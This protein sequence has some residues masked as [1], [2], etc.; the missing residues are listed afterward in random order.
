[1]KNLIVTLT[2]I[3]LTLTACQADEPTC[4]DYLDEQIESMLLICEENPQLTAACGCWE[5]G[6]DLN[7]ETCGCMPEGKLEEFSLRRCEPADEGWLLEAA[8]LAQASCQ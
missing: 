3:S 4:E 6:L 7:L 2:I 8:D 1:M 5:Q